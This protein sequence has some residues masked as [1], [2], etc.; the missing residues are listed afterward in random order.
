MFPY[1]GLMAWAAFI[2]KIMFSPLNGSDTVVL[3]YMYVSFL[4]PWFLPWVCLFDLVSTPHCLNYHSFL[5][6][7]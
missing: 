5:T 6:M 3:P 4:A 1:G 2:E 7:S